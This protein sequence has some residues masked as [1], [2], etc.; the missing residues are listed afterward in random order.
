MVLCCNIKI[1]RMN[2]QGTQKHIQQFIYTQRDPKVFE[3]QFDSY[4]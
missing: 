2:R 4:Q 1:Y 3:L